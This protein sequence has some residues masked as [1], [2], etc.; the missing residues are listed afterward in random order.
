MGKH[1]VIF[2]AW[3]ERFIKEVD[4]CI[5]RSQV[6][7]G[8]DR[9][10]VT[11]LETDLSGLE[12]QF[13]E[14]I[15]APFETQGHLRKA[16][17]I[18]F[19]PETYEVFLFLDSDTVVIE[20]ISL[21]FEKAEKFLIA[22]APAPN[23][24][25]DYFLGFGKVMDLEG[26]PRK[27]Q[28]VYNSGVIFFKNIPI[29]RSVFERWMELTLKHQDIFKKDQAFLTL[30]MEELEL[31]PYTLPITYNYRGI[32]DNI[33]GV[34]RVWHNHGKLPE[35]INVIKEDEFSWPPRKAYPAKVVYRGKELDVV[36][37]L[38]RVKQ[39]IVRRW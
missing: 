31:N 39:R 8:Y 6:I 3:G 38:R 29:V 25:L 12:S 33:C 11:D 1:A 26:I 27:G 7:Q 19:L 20:D 34:V 5:A 2:L 28:L 24:S 16:E 35:K 36:R 23:Y 13:S 9:I 4:S 17:L 21:G 15:R 14:I 30:A 22:M 32:G 18:R 37:I 10:L